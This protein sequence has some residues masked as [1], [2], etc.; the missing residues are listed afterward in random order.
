MPPPTHTTTASAPGKLILFGEHAVVHGQ[1]ALAVPLSA[2]RV[3]VRAEPMPPGTGTLIHTPDLERSI[4]VSV[5][6]DPIPD[7]LHTALAYPIQVARRALNVPLPDMMLIVN[8]TIP[9]ASGLGSGAALAAAL[10]RAFTDA[11]D[12]P[13]SNDAL[14]PLVY[15]VEKQHHGTPSGIDN[16][17]IVYEKPVYF[18][19]GQP[20]EPFT[21]ARPFT[22]LVADTG[23]PSPTH[24]AVGDVRALYEAEPDRTGAIFREIGQI[25]E[26]ARQ[27][28]ESGAAESGT[29][30][31]ST[32]ESPGPLIGSLMDANHALLR[33]LTVSSPALNALCAAARNA[34]AWGAKLSGGGRGGNLIAL[35]PPDRAEHISRALRTAGAVGVIE[36][37]V[38]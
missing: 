6:P 34:G 21:I 8:S 11:L 17:V 29:T 4:R 20:P 10:I 9:I 31:S 16:T 33:D 22:L 13:L 23:N 15:E 1:P 24:I 19:R 30:G 35:V 28:I 12:R 25:V 3:T 26:Q 36:T 32:I 18:V 14:N 5:E 7:R 38:T 27:I 2:V 37:T